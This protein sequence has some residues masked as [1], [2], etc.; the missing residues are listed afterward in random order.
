MKKNK[1]NLIVSSII[2]LILAIGIFQLYLKSKE[3]TLSAGGASL[4]NR[5]ILM[6]AILKPRKVIINLEIDNSKCNKVLQY[7]IKNPNGFTIKKGTI[8]PHDGL[9]LNP[10]ECNGIKGDW[11]IQLKKS[12]E[13]NYFKYKYTFKTSNGLF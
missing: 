5:T 12:E 8:K 4:K 13:N 9:K 2:L 6:N 3:I 7:S 11:K 1:L 10:L